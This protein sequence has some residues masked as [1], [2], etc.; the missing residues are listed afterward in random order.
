MRTILIF[1]LLLLGGCQHIHDLFVPV[2]SLN[3]SG[4]YQ[5]KSSDNDGV[6]TFNHLRFYP[7]G[8]V[9]GLRSSSDAKTIRHWF[10]QE[11]RSLLQGEYTRL[12]NEISFFLNYLRSTENKNDFDYEGKLL[13]KKVKLK[14]SKPYENGLRELEYYLIKDSEN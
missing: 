7:D 9:I 12:G 5:A 1:T 13:Y 4:I 8:K 6:E 14:R 2:H 11:D 10:N 3:H